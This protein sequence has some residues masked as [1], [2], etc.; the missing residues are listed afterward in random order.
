[1]ISFKWRQFE[2]S[3]IL[4]L[5]RWYLAYSLSYRDTLCANISETRNRVKLLSGGIEQMHEKRITGH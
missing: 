4:M 5:V 3:I 1:M 2:Q